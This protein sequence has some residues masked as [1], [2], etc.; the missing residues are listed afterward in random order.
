MFRLACPHPSLRA[1]LSLSRAVLLNR[2][3]ERGQPFAFREFGYFVWWRNP[4]LEKRGGRDLKKNDAKPPLM[5]RTGWSLTTMFR[6]V[7]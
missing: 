3:R 5:E 7:L 1:T 2:E 6:N 4:L